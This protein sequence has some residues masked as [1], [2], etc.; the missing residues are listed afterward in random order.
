MG[1]TAYRSRSGPGILVRAVRWSAYLDTEDELVFYCPECAKRE[2]AK[3]D[4]CAV[5]PRASQRDQEKLKAAKGIGHVLIIDQPRRTRAAKTVRI[6]DH[7]VFPRALNDHRQYRVGR[8][9]RL[10]YSGG[11]RR[12]TQHL[13]LSVVFR[14]RAEQRP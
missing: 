1:Q 3:D 8:D 6:N 13:H 12:L 11:E 7:F 5:L 10:E 14:N 9:R 2:F 4:L